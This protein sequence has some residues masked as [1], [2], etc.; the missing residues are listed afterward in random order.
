MRSLEEIE[1]W[2]K[3]MK[4][5]IEAGPPLFWAQCSI[6]DKIEG[7]QTDEHHVNTGWTSS[8]DDDW[9]CPACSK[10]ENDV[11]NHH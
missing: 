10:G 9:I 4:K 11:S 7:G 1:A 2:A 8:A 3:K 6:C 5:E